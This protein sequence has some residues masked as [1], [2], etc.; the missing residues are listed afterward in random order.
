M[1]ASTH[2]LFAAAIA[3]MLTITGFEQLIVMPAVPAAPIVT[4]AAPV[5]A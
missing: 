1:S 5:L 4:I 2:R 3:V